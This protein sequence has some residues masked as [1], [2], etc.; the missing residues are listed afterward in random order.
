MVFELQ[1]CKKSIAVRQCLLTN[2]MLKKYPYQEIILQK[3]LEP[4]PRQM[5]ATGVP[6]ALF[7]IHV[8]GEAANDLIQLMEIYRKGV[9]IEMSTA[10]DSYLCCIKRKF[11]G[12]NEMGIFGTVEIMS[13]CFTELPKDPIYCKKFMFVCG[14]DEKIGTS[15]TKLHTKVVELR[16]LAFL[17]RFTD[18]TRKKSEKEFLFSQSPTIKNPPKR[19]KIDLIVAKHLGV[20]VFE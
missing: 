15:I 18:S 20:N 8:I 19:V 9:T 7:N 13:A 16:Y 11:L 14:F 3:V 12:C 4:P 17:R 1:T 2:A 6:S 5:R 10:Y